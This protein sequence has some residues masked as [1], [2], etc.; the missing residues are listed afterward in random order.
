MRL[1]ATTGL[2]SARHGAA[3]AFTGAAVLGAARNMMLATVM[4]F[5][6]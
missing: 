5:Q 4:R 2:S 1:D 6:L 3:D